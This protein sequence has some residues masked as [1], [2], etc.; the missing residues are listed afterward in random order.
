MSK[1]KVVA[2]DLD[3]TLT[4]HKSK[5]SEETRKMLDCLGARYKLIMVG[6]GV[7]NRIFEQMNRYPIDI[8]GNYGMQY[9]VYDHETASLRFIRDE[10]YAC[11]RERVAKTVAELRKKYG[12]LEFKGEGVE[13]HASGAVTIPILGTDADL[14]DKLVYDPDRKKRRAIYEEVCATF[15]EYTVFVGGSS[16]FDMVPKPFNKFYALE[17]FAKEYGFSYDEIAYV[18][19]DYG[20]G[21]NDESVYQSDIPFFCVDNYRE[22][23]NV[24]KP[25]LNG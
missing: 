8:I 10:K 13:F 25:L 2:F 9:A 16:S 19:D 17:L 4:Q 23:A 18:G 22:V 6:A 12:W 24:L 20:P 5:L 21:G 15:P 1:I 14:S 11:D 7:C 3:G